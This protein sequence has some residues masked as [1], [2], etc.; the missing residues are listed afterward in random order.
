[1]HNQE[2]Y[3][4]EFGANV[5]TYLEPKAPA[6]VGGISLDGGLQ[7]LSDTST[8]SLAAWLVGGLLGALIVSGS[9]VAGAGA[10][11]RSRSER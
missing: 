10:W 4:A 11:A 2:Y 5:I 1:M 9:I 7:G 6:P 3:I 8:T